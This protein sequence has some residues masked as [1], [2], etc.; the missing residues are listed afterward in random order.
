MVKK[1]CNQLVPSKGE[2]MDVDLELLNSIEL[3]KNNIIKVMDNFQISSYL[4]EVFD[5]ISD[6]NKYFSNQKPWELKSV[7][8]GRMNTVLWVTCEML[9]RFGILLQ[10]VI[11]SGSSMLLGLLSIS[12]KE[13]TI[14]FLNDDY[15]LTPGDP[16]QNPEVIFPKIEL[17]E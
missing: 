6:T 17:K 1:N 9:R 12:E 8:E 15:S 4:S 5:T 7:D 16:I 10:P 3:K 2:L 14:D 13:R 11:P